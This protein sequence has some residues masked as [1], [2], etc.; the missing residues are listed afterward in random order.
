MLRLEHLFSQ[1]R[2]YLAGNASWDSRV[3]IAT[4][5][6]ILDLFS[7]GDL[8]TEILKEVERATNNLKR[9][10]EY[11]NV[12]HT[13]LKT[14]LRALD[15]VYNGLHGTNHQLGQTLREDE[16][17]AGIRQRTSI[18]GGT[19]DFDLPAFH[20]WLQRPSDQRAAAQTEWFS[21]LEAVRQAVELVLKLIRNSAE[22]SEQ[23]AEGGAYQQALD[24][25][26]PY[27]L[28]RIQLPSNASYYPEV[29]GGRHRFTI[30]FLSLTDNKRPKQT[31][32]DLQFQVACCNL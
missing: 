22:F 32:E 7:R 25:N 28:I 10:M 15:H 19:C 18:P 29:S 6:N 9:L 27:Q 2:H 26:Q 5:M 13:R 12:D 16:F 30:R 11:P 14:I 31:N 8:K 21:S 23:M 20:Q 17:L 4:L 24:P 1:A 3:F